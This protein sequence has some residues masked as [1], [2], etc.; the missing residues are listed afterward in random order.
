[1]LLTIRNPKSEIR[2]QQFPM[3]HIPYATAMPPPLPF[4]DRRGAL[5]AMGVILIVIGAGWGL[6]F[7][8]S[9]AMVLAFRSAG[10]APPGGQPP[11]QS[12][13]RDLATG[14]VVNLAVS[15]FFVWTGAGSVRVRRWVRPIILI[16]AWAW[17]LAG[18][19][20]G[21]M[22]AVMAPDLGRVMA[23]SRGPGTPPL[24]PG[25]LRGMMVFMGVLFLVIFIAAPA[26]LILL[27]RS[28]HVQSTLN[29]FDPRPNWTDRCPMPVLGWSLG[30]LLGAAML[31]LNVLKPVVPALGWVL[32][33]LPAVAALL[34]MAAAWAWVARATYRLQPAGW[35]ASLLLTAL[36]GAFYAY[37][38]VRTDWR[39]VF[40]LQ[41]QP[42]EQARMMAE[43][44]LLQ[45]SRGAVVV[46]GFTALL[47]VYLLYIRKFFRPGGADQQQ[48]PPLPAS[49]PAMP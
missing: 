21:V 40:E 14:V 38:A 3:T 27:Y 6:L 45:G 23:A 39:A 37:T 42:P 26:A 31:L 16:A 32:T 17:L 12:A 7:L 34:A 41:G 11:P 18:I 13:P 10:V 46:A 43:M 49:P 24:P 33:G 4:K 8:G 29:Y 44:G 22:L 35:W 5:K 47:L 28:P 1:M 25:V 48:V 30:A 19:A 15:A 9:V 20:S 36:G 2:N